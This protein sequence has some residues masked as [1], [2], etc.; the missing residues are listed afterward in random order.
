MLSEVN[1][2]KLITGIKPTGDLTL[3]NYLGVIK[4]IVNL[5]EKYNSKYDFYVFIADLHSFTS[6]QEPSILK[7]RAED[8]ALLCLASGLKIEQTNLFI[9]SEILQHTYLSYIMESI[10]YVGELKRMIQFKEYEKKTSSGN[11]R[12]SVLTY[13]LLMSSDILLYDADFVL[14]GQDQKQ[15]LELTRLLATRFNNLY[16]NTFIVP[17]FISYNYMIKSL[18]DPLKKMSKSNKTLNSL[19]DDKGCIFLSEDLNNIRT[20]ILK[21]VTDS[22]N[23][24]EYNSKTKPGIS[25]LLTIYAIFKNWTL[26]ETEKYFKNYDYDNFK[27]RLA[28]LVVEK[29]KII[30]QNFFNL[31]SN[32]LLKKVLDF[33]AKKASLIAEEKIKKIN[34]KMGIFR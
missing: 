18:S 8:I 29:I 26:E 11:I 17:E 28:D 20:K 12:T 27:S 13:P 15:H 24:I 5:Q 2:K 22:E 19:K 33:G 34:Q 1:K 3:G 9:Q 10:S 6:F 7:K 21:A 23:K 14:V 16:G 31:K 32:D 25:N 4:N 30:Q